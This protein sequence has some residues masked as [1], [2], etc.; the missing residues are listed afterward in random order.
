MYTVDYTRQLKILEDLD[1]SFPS[2]HHLD[3]AYFIPLECPP[4]HRALALRDRPSQKH[5]QDHFFETVTVAPDHPMFTS[6]R[7]LISPMSKAIGIPLIVYLEAPLAHPFMH[8]EYPEYVNHAVTSLLAKPR[9]G[10][11]NFE[12]REGLGT[13]LVA[14]LDHQPFSIGLL[15]TIHAYVTMLENERYKAIDESKYV[16]VEYT[17]TPSDFAE[18]S[19]KFISN[20]RMSFHKEWDIEL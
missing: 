3:P 13:A 4:K 20:T 6:G 10:E 2:G 8:Q 14:R 11:P 1:K 9:T 5:T 7:S 15:T 16:Q 12:H 17:I 18:F 19:R